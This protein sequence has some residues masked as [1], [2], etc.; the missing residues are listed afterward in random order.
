MI[1]KEPFWRPINWSFQQGNKGF[2]K[3]AVNSGLP[4]MVKFGKWM[5]NFYWWDFIKII[6]LVGKKKV[7][8]TLFLYLKHHEEVQLDWQ[9]FEIF[10]FSSIL[11]SL[12]SAK[13]IEEKLTYRFLRF[14]IC[15]TS[16]SNQS[17]Q[18]SWFFQTKWKT[19]TK[20]KNRRL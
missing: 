6:V 18:L 2:W 15:V 17:S 19:M 7:Q 4:K 1:L 14:R 8:L 11:P 12:L 5:N 10:I 16:T 3:L 20:S 13:M 9:H